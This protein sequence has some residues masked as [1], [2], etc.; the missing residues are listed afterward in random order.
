MIVIDVDN[1]S[2]DDVVCVAV[3]ILDPQHARGLS[4]AAR[5]PAGAV[6]RWR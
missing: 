4:A 1:T 3:E 5:T 6:G 2:A